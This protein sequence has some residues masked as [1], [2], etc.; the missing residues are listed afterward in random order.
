MILLHVRLED[1]KFYNIKT[2]GDGIVHEFLCYEYKYGSW[3]GIKYVV[4]VDDLGV[5]DVFLCWM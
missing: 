4:F 3:K 2:I 1:V 5:I